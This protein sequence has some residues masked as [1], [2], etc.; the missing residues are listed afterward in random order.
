MDLKIGEIVDISGHHGWKRG[1]IFQKTKYL[2]QKD[3]YLVR[4]NNASMCYISGKY[5]TPVKMPKLKEYR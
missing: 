5:L 3:V 2:D 1:T 4:V